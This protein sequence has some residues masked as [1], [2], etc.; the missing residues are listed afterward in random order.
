[1]NVSLKQLRAFV[2]VAETHSFTKAASALHSTQSAISVL[3]RDLEQEIG[4]RLLDRTTRQVVLSDAGREFF[5]MASKLLEDF[6]S[7]VQDAN[8]IA[9]LRRGVVRVGAAEAVACSLVIPAVAAFNRA[10]PDIDV[11]LVV[12]PVPSM[13]S[14]LRSGEVDFIIGPDSMHEVELDAGVQQEALHKSPLVA[15]CPRDH[16]L[17]QKAQISWSELLQNDLVLS[18]MDFSTRIIPLV[19]QHLGDAWVDEAL[20]ATAAR[21]SVA[22]VPAALCMV[23][24]GLGVT[25][26]AEY[27]RPLASLFQLEGRPI[28][29]PALYR[30]L[31]LLS[32]SQRSISPSAQS[33]ATFFRESLQDT[34][35]AAERD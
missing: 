21:R 19:K 29:E 8:D 16:A 26:A 31:V 12:T 20:D 5:V 18:A 9:M 24:E 30:T 11:R 27:I 32:R 1:M 28:V 34:G 14:A 4:F 2:T 33:F 15:W 17:A 25:F 23:R 13:L 35:P 6:R 7:V 22:N 10:N 3:V